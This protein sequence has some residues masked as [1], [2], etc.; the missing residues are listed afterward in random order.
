MV[1]RRSENATQRE[2]IAAAWR[3]QACGKGQDEPTAYE[4]SVI[5]KALLAISR[6]QDEVAAASKEASLCKVV[7]IGCELPQPAGKVWPKAI[8]V[9]DS[10]NLAPR[11]VRKAM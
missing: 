6:Q 7:A 2:G 3:I 9:T 5:R 1:N 10:T 4:L 11:M 8:K